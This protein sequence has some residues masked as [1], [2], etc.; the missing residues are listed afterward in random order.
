M[1]RKA[2][3]F[4]WG[5]VIASTLVMSGF[6]GTY[7]TFSVFLKPILEELVWTRAVTSGAIST[8]AGVSGLATI[9][10]G[11]LADKY[12]ERIIVVIGALL[13]GLGYLLMSQISS[14]WQLYLYFGIII[15]IGMAA[16]WTPINAA[17]SKRFI[18]KRILAL[19]IA[20]SGMTIGQMYMAPIT[21][22]WITTYGWH[23]AYIMLAIILILTIIPSLKLPG[24]ITQQI[25][26]IGVRGRKEED[27]KSNQFE[28][29]T[30]PNE[31]SATE[32]AKTLP[33]WMLMVTGFAISTCFYIVIVHIV[34]YATDIG[35]VSTMAALIITIMGGANILGKVVVEYGTNRIGSKST[36]FILLV[37]QALALLL[38]MQA[39]SL[40]MLFAAGSLFGLG[41]GATSPIRISMISEFFGFKSVG[42]LIGLID[43]SWCVGGIT[44]PVL[45]GYIF[46]LS[47]SYDMA[48]IAG[49][50]LT[51]IGMIATPF[52]RTPSRQ[53]G[54]LW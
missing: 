17:I 12:G 30:Q 35:I 20:T 36:L 16:C 51:V 25:I 18:E 40:W 38:F 41:N 49:M 26:G 13:V 1:K 21:V 28:E 39:S 32:A 10:A 5:L 11:R 23:I 22:H 31:W 54:K 29:P 43:V 52:L 44:G 7:H 15:G 27:S 46:D 9:I 4:D 8:S 48:F 50:L 37:L 45:A 3:P 6:Y 19:G 42:T 53:A 34:A 2:L 14:I 47:Q 33:F 24:R